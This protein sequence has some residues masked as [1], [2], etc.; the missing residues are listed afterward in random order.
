MPQLRFV[1]ITKPY[2]E[3]FV[4]TATEEEKRVMGVHFV[5]LKELLEKKILIMAGP[6]TSGKFGLTVI[7]TASEEQAREIMNNDPAV[8]SGLVSAEIY[9]Y[10]VSLIRK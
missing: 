10:R 9:P 1:Y 6:E 4:E 2:K 3:N 7:E 5:Y 8:K